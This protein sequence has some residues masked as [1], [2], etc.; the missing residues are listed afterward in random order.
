MLLLNAFPQLNIHR[1]VTA[2]WT[3]SCDFLTE[4]S[5]PKPVHTLFR[6]LYM[7]SEPIIQKPACGD[8]VDPGSWRR[9]RLI[10]AGHL[11][12]GFRSLYDGLLLPA[13]PPTDHSARRGDRVTLTMP[14]PHQEVEVFRFASTGDGL[15][16]CTARGEFVPWDLT[17]LTANGQKM[18]A[19]FED[20]E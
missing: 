12:A 11:R 17:S 6:G 10:S 2:G 7:T 18:L 8:W 15:I 4:K 16:P 13:H 19:A 14:S 5:R 1:R 3:A 9:E 20:G